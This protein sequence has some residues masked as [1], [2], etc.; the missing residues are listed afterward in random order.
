[1][2]TKGYYRWKP[3]YFSDGTWRNLLYDIKKRYMIIGKD[4][5]IKERKVNSTQLFHVIIEA[6][7]KSPNTN[8]ATQAEICGAI[9]AWLKNCRARLTTASKRTTTSE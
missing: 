3:A 6:V 5:S 4:G 9:M 8:S 2:A 1:M 7:Q